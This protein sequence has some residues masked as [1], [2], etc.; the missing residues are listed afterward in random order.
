MDDLVIKQLRDLYGLN[1]EIPHRAFQFPRLPPGI[2]HP[3]F[4]IHENPTKEKFSQDTASLNK[5][6]DGFQKLYQQHAS[7]LMGMNSSTIIPPGHPL[8][9][10][11][12]SIESL[13][14]ENDKLL[15]QNLELKKKLDKENSNHN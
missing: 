1:P 7:G 13:K 2:T 14:A 4:K 3:M 11:K 6:L 8:F 5:K 10:E 15:K 12:N 9:S